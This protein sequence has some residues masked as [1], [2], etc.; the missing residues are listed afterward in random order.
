VSHQWAFFAFLAAGV[1]LLAVVTGVAARLSV[2]AYA[3][4]VAGLFGV[5]A[6]YHRVPWK[7]GARRRM[8]RLDHAMI[9]VLVAGTTTPIAVVGLDPAWA[10]ALLAV[11]WSGALA[12][13][14]LSV[15]WIDGPGW[16]PAVVGVA[17]GWASAFALPTVID[18]L[19]LGAAGLVVAGGVLYSVGAVVYVTRRPDP[20][21]ATFGYHEVFHALVIGAAALHFA[22]VAAVVLG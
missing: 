4:S 18:S 9:F 16:L 7:P 13:V 10:A 11:V 12:G 2:G 15:C 8:R 21:P 5:S 1:A 17:T 6:L 14:L 19:G 20:V 3:V 22:A